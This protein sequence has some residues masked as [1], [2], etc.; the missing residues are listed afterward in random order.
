MERVIATRIANRAGADGEA[1][2][3]QPVQPLD[4][5]HFTASSQEWLD[6]STRD[7]NIIS[8]VESSQSLPREQILSYLLPTAPDSGGNDV[9]SGIDVYDAFSKQTVNSEELNT[10]V[11]DKEQLGAD[12]PY[13]P[14]KPQQ[15]V[16]SSLQKWE[17]VVLQV[18]LE[19]II[20]R[21]VDLTQPGASEEEAEIPLNELSE[22]DR[23]LIQ[24]GAVFY[25]NIGYL[26]SQ[27]GQRTR[28]SIIRFRRLPAWTRK[29]IESAGREAARIRA[30]F[31][32]E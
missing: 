15:S 6:T 1:M 10:P 7:R 21:L 26:D 23:D 17:G 30:A 32:W 19:C 3:S 27:S 12:I 18:T 25:W 22:E 4:F 9:S 5:P 20:A 11:S 31:G 2:N 29:E 13:F 16:F 14:S 24:P 28:V 8:R